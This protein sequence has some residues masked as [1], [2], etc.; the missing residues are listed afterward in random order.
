MVVVG[1]AYLDVGQG[2]QHCCYE[3]RAQAKSHLINKDV[4]KGIFKVSVY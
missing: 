1:A 2:G 4:V 3:A